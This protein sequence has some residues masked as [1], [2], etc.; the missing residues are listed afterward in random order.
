MDLTPVADD[1]LVRRVKRLL[2]D[3]APV[4]VA[5]SGGPDSS[6]LAVLAAGFLG[7][8]AMAL[9]VKAPQTPDS[10]YGPARELAAS[11]GL[12][13]EIISIPFVEDPKQDPGERCYLCQVKLFSR[14]IAR[15]REQGFPRLADGSHR[16][17]TPDGR[18]GLKTLR[19]LGIRSPFQEADLGR[20]DLNELS[21]RLGLP[22][23]ERAPFVCVLTRMPHTAAQGDNGRRLSETE[24]WLR[25]RGFHPDRLRADGDTLRLVLPTSEWLRLEETEVR[26]GLAGKGWSGIGLEMDF[27]PK[28]PF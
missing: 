5:F 25:N 2:E 28:K 27:L 9:T 11:C 4:A 15:G 17:D 23:T 10:A 26:T 16:D 8:R 21:E 12:R 7:D 3:M 20:Q 14:L 24:N 22:W 19:E 18:P 13:H 6:L 1:P